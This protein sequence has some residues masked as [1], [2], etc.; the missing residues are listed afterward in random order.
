MLEIE[1]LSSQLNQCIGFQKKQW[2][3]FQTDNFFTTQQQKWGDTKQFIK[4]K[5]LSILPS[6]TPAQ[7]ALARSRLGQAL[8]QEIALSPQDLY[9]LSAGLIHIS[10]DQMTCLFEEEI[11]FDYLLENYQKSKPSYLIWKNL[12]NQYFFY[13]NW[14]QHPIGKKNWEKLRYYLRNS[15]LNMVKSTMLKQSWMQILY[16]NIGLLEEQATAK[17]VQDV[18]NGKFEIILELAEVLNIPMQTWFWNTICEN[19]IQHIVQKNDLIF[20]TKVN[21]GVDILQY[22][23][24]TKKDFLL[25]LLLQRYLK[26]KERPLQEKLKGS[27][28]KYWDHPY[29][30]MPQWKR[31]PGSRELVRHWCVQEQINDFF[32]VIVKDNKKYQFWMKYSKRIQFSCLILDPACLEL[33]RYAAL[34][35]RKHFSYVTLTQN[36]TGAPL[37]LLLM[38]L[39]ET[40]IVH[41][42][43]P[44]TPLLLFFEKKLGLNYQ[45][46]TLDLATIY[47]PALATWKFLYK[48]D[49]ATVLQKQLATLNIMMNT[50]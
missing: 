27:L 23:S 25:G 43:Q 32:N 4:T 3:G 6:A 12:L 1:K 16:Q 24:D 28:L 30:G 38:K 19:Y 31:V 7:I 2:D 48:G 14:Q 46:M 9:F 34:K 35:Q 18:Y 41:V 37:A 15:F 11:F 49:W 33:A 40:I 45:E 21:Y 8:S 22:A 36:T 39:G 5:I 26:L 13:S 47:A 42:E 44:Q 50:K 20:K 10:D 29:F 17:Y